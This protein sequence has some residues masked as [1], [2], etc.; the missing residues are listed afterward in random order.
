MGDP[1]RVVETPTVGGGAGNEDNV[2]VHTKGPIYVIYVNE[3]TGL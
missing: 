3:A 2:V 1:E